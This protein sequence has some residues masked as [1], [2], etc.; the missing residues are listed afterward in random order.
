[1][2]SFEFLLSMTIL[3]DILFAV[4]TVNKNLSRI[5]NPKHSRTSEMREVEE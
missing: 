2:K 3:Y 5:Q 4:N 1:M